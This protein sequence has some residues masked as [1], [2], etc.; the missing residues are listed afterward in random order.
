M[1]KLIEATSANIPL[2]E[3]Y[4]LKTFMNLPKEEYGKIKNYIQSNI[5]KQIDNYKLIMTD[6]IVGCLL[7]HSY[8]DGVL[9]DEL[10]MEESYRNKGIGTKIIS[11]ISKNKAT[12]L[13]VYKENRKAIELYMR[14]GF[15]IID[16]TETRYFMKKTR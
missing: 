15:N 11:D 16:S 2:I 1:Y 13:W 4:K 10:Y 12:Y 3:Q 14:L 5:P 9:I 7:Y 6:K 8:L